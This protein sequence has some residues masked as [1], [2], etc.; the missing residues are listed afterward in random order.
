L[1]RTCDS[2]DQVINAN[3]II[4]DGSATLWAYAKGLIEQAIQEGYLQL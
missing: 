1:A 3:Q 4:A 2:S